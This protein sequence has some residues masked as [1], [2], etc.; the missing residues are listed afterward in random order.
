MRQAAPDHARFPRLA[1]ARGNTLRLNEGREYH[2][3]NKLFG[4][5]PCRGT[6]KKCR[7][8]VRGDGH[9]ICA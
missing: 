4:N 5:D 6:Y 9:S 7:G 8:R 2:F 1:A 3:Y